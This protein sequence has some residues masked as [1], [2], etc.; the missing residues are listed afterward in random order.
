MDINILENLVPLNFIFLQS[1]KEKNQKNKK[2][3][4]HIVWSDRFIHFPLGFKIFCFYSFGK[5]I[6]AG[7][8]AAGILCFSL[9][10]E[11]IGLRRKIENLKNIAHLP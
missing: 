6:P 3:T 4:P 8:Q 10:N 11:K 2:I 7:Q 1:V 9:E 5:N